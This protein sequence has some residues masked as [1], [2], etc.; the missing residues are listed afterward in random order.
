MKER[1]FDLMEKALSAY[2][3]EHIKNY[4]ERV[5]AEGLTEHGFPRLTVN[6]GILICHGR[7]T[8]LLP[9]F[10]EMMR[11]CVDE[12]PTKKAHNDFSVREVIFC[13]WEAEASGIIPKEETDYWRAKLSEI[14]PYACYT[15]CAK[16]K[17]DPNPHLHNWAIFNSL[18]EYVR[19]KAGLCEPDEYIDIQLST[20]M[21]WI[22]ENGMYRDA[23]VH[24]PIVYDLVPR[25]LL[26]M[27]LHFG[28]RGEYY[29]Q[30][31][32]A[33][34]KAGLLTLDMQSVT[35]ELGFGGRSNGFIH[36]ES[37]I[38][39]VCAFEAA[40]YK[41]EGNMAL[42]SRFMTA[43]DRALDVVEHWLSKEGI[44]HIKNRYPIDSGYG[45]EVYAYFDKY[46]ITAAS[47]LYASY[48]MTDDSIPYDKN[49]PLGDVTCVTSS[50]FHKV[51]M[52]RGSYALEFDTNGDPHYDASGLGRVHKA[53]KPSAI[54]LSCP[55]PP[56]N[57][58]YVTEAGVSPLSICP[59]RLIEAG[60]ARF[61]TL[62]PHTLVSLTEDTATF[63]C[64]VE[65]ETLSASYFVDETG[66]T[67]TV[68]G[69][70]RIALL[71]PAFAFDGETETEIAAS[72]H[73]ISIFYENAVCRYVTDGTVADSVCYG[74]NRNGRYR[75]Y[76]AEAEKVLTV[77][78]SID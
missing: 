68:S 77:K 5:K 69:E 62:S 23:I 61:A 45:C 76:Y 26:S 4:F 10:C 15:C 25:G 75:G 9:L 34:R 27:L 49:A 17:N 24:P 63:T 56:E 72:E 3:D 37:W 39:L 54:C 16:E 2:T 52:R 40:R 59:G 74:A 36:N 73:S 64:E 41:R 43:A 12:I 48:L 46:M 60:E 51:F 11:F 21:K 32:A 55:C 65:G 71:L 67:V 35:G 58:N 70:G 66:V 38:T 8:D 31:D 44:R 28:Y 18:S 78:I 29:E 42:A 14:E 30:I 13:L 50:D 20:Q 53:D 19:G 6:I 1:Y 7:R 47:F 33:L 22:D 57:A